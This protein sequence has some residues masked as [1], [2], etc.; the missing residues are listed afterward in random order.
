MIV[1]F[2]KFRETEAASPSRLGDLDYSPL[3]YKQKKESSDKEATVFM[4]FGSLV[5]CLLTEPEKFDK[6][7]NICSIE[8]PSDNIKNIVTGVFN[9]Y[10]EN[11][12]DP[13]GKNG[14]V[15]FLALDDFKSDILKHAKFEGYGQTWKE[16]TLFNKVKTGGQD[17]FMSLLSSIG[18]EMISFENYE[19]AVACVETLKTNDFTCEYFTDVEREGIEHLWQV[20]IVWKEEGMTC[21][22]LIDLLLIDHVNKIIYI[23]DLKTTAKSVYSFEHSYIKFRYYLQGSMYFHG[24]VR[25]FGGNPDFKDYSVQN[26]MFIVAEQNDYNP[27]F[28]YQMSAMDLRVGLDGGSLKSSGKLVRGYQELLED[29]A[30]HQ[31]TDIWD[32]PKKVYLDKGKITL[33]VFEDYL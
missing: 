8:F 22:G 21:K 13:K 17:F 32:Y 3:L 14:T 11:I 1:E 29:L 12:N 31:E 7:Y 18:K 25:V 5:D 4:R 6:K 20:P 30:W 33:N 26:T 19:Q 27:P 24:A 2:D 9:E 28:I 10:V 15:A 23:I 16:D